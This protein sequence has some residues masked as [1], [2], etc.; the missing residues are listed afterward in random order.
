MA[1][2]NKASQLQHNGVTL[3]YSAAAGHAHVQP[4]GVTKHSGINK[5]YFAKAVSFQ[6]YMPAYFALIHQCGM[7]YGFNDQ[8]PN[9]DGK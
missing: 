2:S 4:A 7:I 3:N 9:I 5:H 6:D 8:R 1:H